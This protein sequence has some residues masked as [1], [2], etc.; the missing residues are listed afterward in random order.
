MLGR[1]VCPEG[2]VRLLA[3]LD[4]QRT[5][6]VIELLLG[7]ALNV[8]VNRHGGRGRRKV[9]VEMYLL[10]SKGKGLEC[11]LVGLRRVLRPLRRLAIPESVRELVDGEVVLCLKEPDRKA[12]QALQ[13]KR[14]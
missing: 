4:D 5:D 3:I 10:H 14:T 8:E 9:P 2:V 1:A 6:Q 12:F 13:N 11:V 7:Q